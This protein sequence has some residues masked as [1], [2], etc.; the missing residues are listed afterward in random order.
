MECDLDQRIKAWLAKKSI[1]MHGEAQ[2]KNYAEI[3]VFHG[4]KLSGEIRVTQIDDVG[5]S[6][7]I[8][9][10]RDRFELE[11]YWCDNAGFARILEDSFSFL[12][13][14]I[15]TTAPDWSVHLL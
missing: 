15:G 10:M 1:P 6:F 12:A 9:L 3:G 8:C 13:R 5:H 7:H 4:S 11:E 14:A 2:R